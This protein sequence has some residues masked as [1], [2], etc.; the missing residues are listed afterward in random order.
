MDR[1]LGF[2]AGPFR[3]AA[4]LSAVRQILDD[5]TAATRHARDLAEVLGAGAPSSPSSASG[6]PTAATAGAVLVFDADDDAVPL[7]CSTLRGVIDAPAPAPLPQTVA[8]RWPGLLL[9]TIEDDGAL[10]LVLDPRVLIG[11]CEA[12]APTTS[13]ETTS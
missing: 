7:R 6:T 10:T 4:P 11:L 2:D 1:Y 12:A 5:T 9:G 3:L 13:P 8:C